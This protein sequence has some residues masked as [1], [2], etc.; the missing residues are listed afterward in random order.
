MSHVFL[1]DVI[2]RNIQE[3]FPGTQVEGAHLFRII[4]D[5]DMVI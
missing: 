2:R 1:E 3:L 4:R 5:T